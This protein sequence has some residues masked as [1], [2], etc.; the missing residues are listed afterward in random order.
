M[1]LVFIAIIGFWFYMATLSF[2]RSSMDYND[3]VHVNGILNG[4]RHVTHFE[5]PDKFETKKQ[6]VDV[7][8]F[9][10]DGF[11]TEFGIPEGDEN[12][13]SVKGILKSSDSCIIDMY[14]DPN[15]MRIEYGITL[16]IFELKINDKTIVTL[17]QTKNRDRKG[18]LI[19]GLIGFF[20]IGLNI[21]AIKG[22]KK[23]DT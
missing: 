9:N 20:F 7:M 10:V 17:Q 15:G 11:D 23:S 8:A 12:Y 5:P 22:F 1:Q 6:E 4:Y 19:F 2:I 16:H 13:A 14:Y 18:I 21:Y 3:M